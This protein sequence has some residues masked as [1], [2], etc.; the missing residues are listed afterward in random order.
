LA[1]QRLSKV[2]PTTV[3][4]ADFLEWAVPIAGDAGLFADHTEGASAFDV[5]IA[6]PPYVRTQVLGARISQALAAR[7]GLRGRLD[8]AY[9]FCL[10]MLETL[11][12]GGTFAFI[13]SNKF[14]NI[15]AGASLRQF[16]LGKADIL[17]VWD[18]GDSRLF[19]AAVLPCVV[20]GRRKGGQAAG[21][22]AFRS[23]YE[24]P[25]SS[26][27][28][29]VRVVQDDAEAL[30]VLASAAEP[31][32]IVWKGK[33]WA[34]RVGTLGVRQGT[35]NWILEDNAVNEIQGHVATRRAHKLGNILRIGVGVKTTADR[36]FIRRDWTSLP[37]HACP[38]PELLWP[39]RLASDV[40]RWRVTPLA[41]LEHSILY[42]YTRISDK[43]EV[44]DLADF[45]RA[46]TYL[47]QHRATLESR[48]Y[49][50][51]SGR[52]WFEPWVPQ[53][54]GLWKRPRIVFRDIAE[55]AT[56]AL[57]S[58]GAVANGTL[59]WMA[60]RGG[61]S[62]D[63]LKAACAIANSAFAGRFYDLL[64]G[65]R[66]YAG[67]RRFLTQHVNEFPFPSK[68][69]EVRLLAELHDAVTTAANDRAP[70]GVSAAEREID[71]LCDYLFDA[72]SLSRD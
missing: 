38:E 12:P 52:Q 58:T 66:L 4:V 19:K 14:L 61:G 35:R 40:E 13:L 53:Q 48:K 59:Y 56:F 29:P 68:D 11:V 33:H 54:P 65:T 16:L 67:R 22:A 34:V 57:D 32:S 41:S 28:A 51:E 2:V 44:I 10:S 71:R 69:D 27:H 70:D 39:I 46:A 7:Y 15:K 62:V 26:Q 55:R 3:H 8:L 24:S 18:L 9:A 36:V 20:Y 37:P 21:P 64:L 23:I 50:I 5:I 45:P 60:L 31:M 30:T 17:E 43:R 47:E 63:H 6:N 49:V 42:P 25:T 72:G 1:R